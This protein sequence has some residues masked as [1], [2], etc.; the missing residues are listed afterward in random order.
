MD[1]WLSHVSVLDISTSIGGPFCAKLL[2]QL[3]AEVIKVEQPG[4]GDPARSRS[5]FFEDRPHK[6]G[7]GLFLYL[8]SGKKSVTLDMSAAAGRRIFKELVRES[9]VL[10]ESRAPGA[11]SELG[12]SHQAIAAT[13]PGLVTISV[14]D[15]GQW[16]PYKDYKANELIHFAISGL[17]YP[18]GFPE[19]EPIQ[20]GGFLPQYKAGLVGAIG[21]LAALQWRDRT[22]RGQHLDVSALEVAADFLETTLIFYSYQGI[23]RKRTGS[24]LTPPT[25]MCD[26]YQCRDGYMI[27]TVL[28]QQQFQSLCEMMGHADFLDDPEVSNPRALS[29]A[30]KARL[31]DALRSWFREQSTNEAF[32]LCQLLRVPSAKVMSPREMLHDPHLMERRF[33]Q[34]VDHPH[35]GPV[36]YPT[37]GLRTGRTP[38]KPRPAPL[39]GQSNDEV[40]RHR[41]GF[42]NSEMERLGA[43]GVI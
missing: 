4:A 22:G 2:G 40:Y 13:S 23:V 21:V 31:W 9:D 25:P 10:V 39:L 19:R 17:L 3:G 34:G 30:G 42:S 32:E 41:L 43:A 15:F 38:S 14:T 37:T 7:S 5:P 35:T 26:M 27:L 11:M 6:E 33:F 29:D 16:G 24:T 28:T 18:T 1:K 8:N 12:L 36:E 20:S